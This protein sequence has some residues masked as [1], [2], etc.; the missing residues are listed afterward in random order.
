[1]FICFA[2]AST[3]SP[4]CF[5]HQMFEASYK[6]SM[7]SPT[8]E[9]IVGAVSGAITVGATSYI[10]WRLQRPAERADALIRENASTMG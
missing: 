5:K 4:A 9:A 8:A 6:M 3:M 2:S 10:V 7:S 1:M